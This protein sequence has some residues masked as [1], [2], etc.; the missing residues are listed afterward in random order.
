MEESYSVL[1]S[2]C[3][4]RPPAAARVAPWG[5]SSAAAPSSRRR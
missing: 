1:L 5:T 4:M 3:P 2:L